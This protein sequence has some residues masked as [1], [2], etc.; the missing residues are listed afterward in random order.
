MNRTYQCDD[1][2][3]GAGLLYAYGKEALLAI[4][5]SDFR[6]LVTVDIPEEEAKIMREQF[7]NDEMSISSLKAY[8]KIYDDLL[9]QVRRVRKSNF[10]QWQSPAWIN[11]RSA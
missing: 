5:A 3:F 1:L 4:D 2:A 7:D 10:K 11:G 6:A 9:N 8:T